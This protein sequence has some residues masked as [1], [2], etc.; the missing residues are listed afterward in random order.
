MTTLIRSHRANEDVKNAQS[1]QEPGNR[2]P[3]L[4]HLYHGANKRRKNAKRGLAKASKSDFQSLTGDRI[5]YIMERKIP[6]KPVCK[7]LQRHLKTNNASQ[8]T[9]GGRYAGSS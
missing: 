1:E 8:S 2:S 7:G 6:A 9:C 4:D 5:I 3:R